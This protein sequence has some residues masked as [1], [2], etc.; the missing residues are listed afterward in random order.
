[1]TS[2]QNGFSSSNRFLFRGNEE[3]HNTADRQAHGI[4]Q[5]EQTQEQA[6]FVGS[7]RQK[8]KKEIKK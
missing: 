8:T 1:M 3:F 6:L 2:A 5:P 7:G 4:R